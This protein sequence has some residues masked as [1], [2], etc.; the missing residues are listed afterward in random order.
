MRHDPRGDS[1]EATPRLPSPSR[2][3][4]P[5]RRRR[6]L[7]AAAVA[8]LLTAFA[9]QA[10]TSLRQKSIT[11]DEIL[12]ITAGYYH[13]ETGDFSLN[14]VN[15]P[16]PKLL[17]ALPLLPLDL[18]LPPAPEDPGAWTMVEQW[19][20]SRAFYYG[21]TAPADEILFRARLPFVGIGVVLGLY[22][23]LWSRRLYGTR[24]AFLALFLFSLSP[25]VLAHT[26]LAALDL[27]VSAFMLASLF[28]FGA[29]VRRPGAGHLAACGTA[30][31]GAMLSKTTGWFLLPILG[32]YGLWLLVARRAELPVWSGLPGL[33]RLAGDRPDRQRALSALAAAL[34][35]GAVALVGFNAAY[36]FQGTLAPIGTERLRAKVES[37]LPEGGVGRRAVEPLLALPSPLPAPFYD[38]LIHQFRTTSYGQRNYLAG[39][40]SREGFWYMLPLAFSLKTPLPILLLTGLALYGMARR[41]SARS[42]EVLILWAALF[43]F[44]FFMYLKNVSIGTRY[45]LLLYPLMHVLAS[46]LLRS[47]VRP[48]PLLAGALALL[49]VWYAVGSARIHPHY[50][51]YFNESIGG[52]EKGWRYLADSHLDWGQDL[53]LL[54]RWMDE[55]GVDRVRLAYAGSGDARYYGIDYEYLPSVGL[56]PLA[57]GDRWWYEDLEENLPPLD[58]TRGPIVVSATLLAGVFLPGYYAPLRELEPVDQIG[59]SLLVFEPRGARETEAARRR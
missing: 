7:R 14:P 43:T 16:L 15:P 11:T 45:V 55:K 18:R 48:K 12:Y 24:A 29:F 6:A 22:V 41:R 25:N 3:R 35:L 33:A 50:L 47:G 42:E 19:K 38:T 8:A 53:K 51:A 30:L 39:E 36:G 46:G 17:A 9:V 57:P 59:Y 23:Y 34:L 56:A 54:R 4:R 21:N 13:L 2:E 31:A 26:R 52:P 10:V 5:E 20:Y 37:R 49:L 44:G 1:E 32:L 27:A 28:H 40:T 58:L